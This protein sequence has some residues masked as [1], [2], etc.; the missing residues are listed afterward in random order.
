MNSMVVTDILDAQ[1]IP[2]EVV[3]HPPA[4]NQAELHLTGIETER[5]VKTLGFTIGDTGR[6]VLVGIRGSGRLSYGHL[7]RALEVSRSQL[8]PTTPEQVAALGMEP[9]GLSPICA[10]P[11]ITV[12]FDVVVPTMGQVAVGGGTATRTLLL[13]AAD[14][15][16]ASPTVLVAPLS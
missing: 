12:V 15:V 16:S 6:V 8:K 9:G 14:L 1:A 13:V 4:R 2:Y 3:E 11:T 10:D 7:A 5:A